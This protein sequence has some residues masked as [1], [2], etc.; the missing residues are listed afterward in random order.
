MEIEGP[1]RVRTPQSFEISRWEKET[2]MKRGSLKKLVAV[3]LVAGAVFLSACTTDQ[4]IDTSVGVV[5][6]TTKVVAKGAV[7]AGKLAYRG[8]KALIVGNE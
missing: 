3:G 2:G 8:G 6:G 7:G 5:A 1:K 4:A